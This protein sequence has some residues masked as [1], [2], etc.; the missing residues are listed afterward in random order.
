M[1]KKYKKIVRIV[2]ISCILIL[3]F[4]F[5]FLIYQ[6]YW[7]EEEK[8]YFDSMN[9]I[10]ILED[11]YISVGSNNNNEKSYEKA[12]ITRYDKEKQKTWER[13]YNKGYNSSFFAIKKDK[14]AYIAVGS[15]E[16]KKQ[17]NKD[18]VRSALIVKYSNEGEI[19]YE[20]NFQV[21]GNSKFTNVLVLEDGYIVVGQSIYEDMTLGLSEAGGAFIIKYNKELK[22][23]WRKNY[24]GSK[25]G[26]YNDVIKVGNYFYAV[27]KDATRVG[28]ISKYTLEGKREKTV[29]YEYTDTLGFT[30]IVE[31]D[32]KLYV[33]GSKKVTEEVEDYNTDALIIKYDLDCN[34]IQQEVYTGEGTE[35]FNKAIVDDN[36]N[37]VIAGQ[38]GIYNKK[39]STPSHNIFSYDGILAKYDSDLKQLELEKYGDEMD[40]YFTDIKQDQDKYLISGYSTYDKNSYLSKFITY[41]KSG[42]LIGEN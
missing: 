14:D 30:G 34:E 6:K 25:S 3:V 2:V 26:I 28:M 32:Q 16:S 8:T 36:Q 27:G 31:L 17:E 24:G 29:H 5:C 22:E 18:G 20:N 42:K 41:S 13:L 10:E 1:N 40:D 38:T 35:R 33:V 19:L 4:D 21:L 11:G 7:K 9:A 39:R 23:V 37:I 15:Y 12:K